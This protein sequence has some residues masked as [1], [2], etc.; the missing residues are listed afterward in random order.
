MSARAGLADLLAP[1]ALD[2]FLNDVW[3]VRHHHGKA[4]RPDRFAD[5]LPDRRLEEILAG[6]QRQADMLSLVK[7]GVRLPLSDFQLPDGCVDIVQLRNKYA[8]GYTVVLNGAERFTPEVR[9]MTNAIAAETDFESQVNVYA[10]PPR[11]RGFS[12]HFDD[13]DVLVL[14]VRGSK[15]WLVYLSSPLVPP[16]RFREKERAVDVS[17]L[18]EPE[19]IELKQGDILYLPRGRVHAAQTGNEASVHLTIGFHPPNLLNVI[20]AS[21]EARGLDGGPLLER[22]RPGYLSDQDKRAD[23]VAQV[24]ELVPTLKPEDVQRGLAAIEDRLIRSGRCAVTGDF[25]GVG[26]T[27]V[28]AQT[29]LRRSAPMPARLLHLGESIGLQF[30]QAVVIAEADHRAAFEFLMAR[31]EAFPVSELPGLSLGAQL[32]LADKL[33]QDG[34]LVKEDPAVAKVRSSI[35]PARRAVS[36]RT[37]TAEPYAAPQPP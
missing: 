4:L 2:S 10:T 17:A 7:E 23:L 20:S 11:A 8:D 27:V 36:R 1:M 30:A 31:D 29:V 34:Y 28:S 21:L 37:R 22:P 6:L 5:L 33:L 35:A 24:C 32:A 26:E 18:G 19:R 14:Q 12:P 16:E 3:G 9:M 15:T 25:I 13:H